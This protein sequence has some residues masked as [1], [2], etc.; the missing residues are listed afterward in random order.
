M[1]Y[2]EY[3]KGEVLTHGRGKGK[4]RPPNFGAR[5][6]RKGFKVNIEEPISVI[7]KNKPSL[8]MSEEERI[9]QESKEM[10][11][12]V[13][14]ASMQYYADTTGFDSYERFKCAEG[15]CLEGTGEEVKESYIML[16]AKE[17]VF[18]ETDMISSIAYE[19]DGHTIKT[20]SLPYVNSNSEIIGNEDLVR[21]YKTHL[22]S[23]VFLNHEHSLKKVKG[24]ILDVVL[25]E[26]NI[27][28]VD[29]PIIAYYSRGLLAVSRKED[30]VLCTAL[31]N[32]EIKFSS[33]GVLYSSIRCSKCGAVTEKNQETGSWDFCIHLSMMKGLRYEDE[34]K[35]IRMVARE[36]TSTKP[37]EEE[38]V[39]AIEFFEQSLLTVD[40]AFSGAIV[41]SSSMETLDV[42]KEL[43]LA[44]G[45]AYLKKPAFTK[46]L[47]DGTIKKVVRNKAKRKSDA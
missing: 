1:T 37:G 43:V 2:S 14:K 6:K 20:E 44:V 35:N 15:V 38:G 12:A 21:F 39:N 22:G 28:T 8:H 33:M 10:V 25:R 24:V 47:Q 18:V 13:H 11:E 23:F 34:G 45:D 31:D 7:E 40:P 4:L 27:G 3:K 41:D 19:A 32:S 5:G 30:P 9:E 26:I 29:E 17:W 46:F 42:E 16:K 36:L